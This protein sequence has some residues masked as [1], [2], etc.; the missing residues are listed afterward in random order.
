MCLEAWGSYLCNCPSCFGGKDCSQNI[1]L[2]RRLKGSSY[3]HYDMYSATPW[4][5]QLP[6]YNGISFRTRQSNGPLM[7]IEFSNNNNK[8]EVEVRSI[9]KSYWCLLCYFF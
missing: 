3:L 7:S 2:P 9:I 8:V 6:W 4:T 5:V 1:E